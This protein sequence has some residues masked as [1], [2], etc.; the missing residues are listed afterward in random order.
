MPTQGPEEQGGSP[1]LQN[2][3]CVKMEVA[4][5]GADQAVPWESPQV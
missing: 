1:R 4:S 5:T 3:P 2:S